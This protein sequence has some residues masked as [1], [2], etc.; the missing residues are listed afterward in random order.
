MPSI[1]S[2]RRVWILDSSSLSPHGMSITCNIHIVLKG[3]AEAF[4]ALEKFLSSIGLQI[5]TVKVSH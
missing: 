3:V 1:T 2:F 4:D 5:L